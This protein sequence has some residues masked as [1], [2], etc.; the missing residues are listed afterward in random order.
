[1]LNQVH[2]TGQMHNHAIIPYQEPTESREEI[3]FVIETPPHF[4]ENK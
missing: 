1:M 3:T 2:L 4:S